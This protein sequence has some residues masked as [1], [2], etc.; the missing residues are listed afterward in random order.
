MWLNFESCCI[1][2]E[3]DKNR[4]IIVGVIYRSHT[5][6]GCFNADIDSILQILTKENKIHYLLGDFNIDL[7]KDETHRPTSDFL[8]LI[9]S[10]HLVP[11]ILRPT[12]ITET[13]AT[14]ID[15]IITN[16]NENIKT[17]IILTDITDHFP[18]VY[19]KNS[20]MFK[21]K[22]TTA[23]KYVYKRIHSDDNVTKFK[24]SLSSD[25]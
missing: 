8:D 11:T 13:S 14:I 5:S 12:R 7:L 2:I 23:D 6:I 22:S 19:H 20:N 15:N 16:S 4:N 24:N 3:N 17:G 25:M 21:Q 10:Y 18:T 1:E 9:Y